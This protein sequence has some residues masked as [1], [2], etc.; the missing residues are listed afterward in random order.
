MGIFTMPDG[1]GA[2][3]ASGTD[4]TSGDGSL[5][6]LFGL[7]GV[8]S[9][10]SVATYTD[11]PTPTST[12]SELGTLQSNGSTAASPIDINAAFADT[13]GTIVA[14]DS[15]NSAASTSGVGYYKAANGGIYQDGTGPGAGSAVVSETPGNL[16]FWLLLI[17]GALLFAKEEHL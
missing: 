3:D 4:T 17:G 12:A 1:T 10:Y 11:P 13:L 8:G 16:L 15:I 5:S 9:G 6:S 2:S 14:L 7:N